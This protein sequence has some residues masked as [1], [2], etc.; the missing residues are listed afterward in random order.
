[1]TLPYNRDQLRLWK[2]QTLAA[3]LA[4]GLEPNRSTI[5]FQ[6]AVWRGS[7]LSHDWPFFDPI[8]GT[9]TYRAHVDSEL[10]RVCGLP[11]PD[12]TVEG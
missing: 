2:R 8:A 5:F 10:Y 12:D 7:K 1:M 3:L 6:S 9:G 11:F 4:I